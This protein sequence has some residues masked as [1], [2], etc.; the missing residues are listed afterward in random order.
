MTKKVIIA[1][2]ALIVTA[3]VS[4]FT[5]AFNERDVKDDLFDANVE[6]L[7]RSEGSGKAICYSQHSVNDSMRCL[8][9]GSCKYV[10]GAGVDKGGYCRF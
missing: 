7:A 5:Y 9:C 8:E 4:A 10:N 2:G 6:A 3:A 1:E